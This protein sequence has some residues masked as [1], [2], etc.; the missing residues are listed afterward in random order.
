MYLN[1]SRNSCRVSS[2]CVRMT[3]VPG[4]E[5]LQHFEAIKSILILDLLHFQD[6]SALSL[7]DKGAVYTELN[8]AFPYH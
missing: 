5:Q 8:R 4:L 7:L 1:P 2:H 6:N 3:R